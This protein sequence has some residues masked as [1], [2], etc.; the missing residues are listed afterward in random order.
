MDWKTE[1][2]CF[3]SLWPCSL[4]RSHAVLD[5][6]KC[7]RQAGRNP[8]E[9]LLGKPGNLCIQTEP[10]VVHVPLPAILLVVA[11]DNMI[12]SHF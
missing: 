9:Q 3:L 7:L 12:Y 1:M 8:K 2:K 4:F 11:E 6:Q 10:S 5:F